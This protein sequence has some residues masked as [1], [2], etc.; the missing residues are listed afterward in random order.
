MRWSLRWETRELGRN[1]RIGSEDFCRTFVRQ[2]QDTF[3]FG[4]CQESR[5]NIFPSK[6]APHFPSPSP[7]TRYSKAVASHRTPQRPCGRKEVARGYRR[8]Q[9]A[10]ME[11]GGFEEANYGNSFA[12]T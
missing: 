4:V 2:I 9:S 12:G 11:S 3:A 5:A 1:V 10:N 6:V 8:I 7:T